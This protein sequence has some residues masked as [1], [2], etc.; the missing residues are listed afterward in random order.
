MYSTYYA[1]KERRRKKRRNSFSE[2]SILYNFHWNL[3]T[4]CPKYL[5]GSQTQVR[6]V[7]YT[8]LRTT[9]NNKLLKNK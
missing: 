5:T 8:N 4:F 6:A 7:K 3:V 2:A 1:K 9:S